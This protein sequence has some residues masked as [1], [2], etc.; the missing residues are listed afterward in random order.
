MNSL[1]LRYQIQI[2][3]KLNHQPEFKLAPQKLNPQLVRMFDNPTMQQQQPARAIQQP[4]KQPVPLKKEAAKTNRCGTWMLSIKQKFQILGKK[5]NA[6][7]QQ[8]LS[9]LKKP[10]TPAKKKMAATPIKSQE[11][12]FQLPL[13]KPVY[14]VRP[15]PFIPVPAQ[16]PHY[17][18][19]KSINR[20][21]PQPKPI[22]TLTMQPDACQNEAKQALPEQAITL[23]E[24]FI[25]P[26]PP[27]PQPKPQISLITVQTNH[28]QSELESILPQKQVEISCEENKPEEQVEQEVQIE[29]KAE[30]TEQMM[31]FPLS[32]SQNDSPEVGEEVKEESHTPP[33]APPLPPRVPI[34][35]AAQ[36]QEIVKPAFRLDRKDFLNEIAQFNKDALKKQEVNTS[37]NT[38]P[39]KDLKQEDDL[40]ELVKKK[41]IIQREPLEDEEEE[42]EVSQTPPIPSTP[43]K[44]PSQ[45]QGTSNN[46]P[47]VKRTGL[48][49]EIEGFKKENLKKA[50]KIN[51]DLPV[52][53]ETASSRN[54]LIKQFMN[55]VAHIGRK[56]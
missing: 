9:F 25:R 32:T 26:L 54:N 28:N 49:N 55:N 53:S 17:T 13:T 1:Q 34:P 19:P 24:R 30:K 42:E 21:L 52:K 4:K 47:R 7:C 16:L 10:F 29:V 44:A 35:V 31:E 38:P 3:Q 51:K 6:C 18:P 12:L 8:V 11:Q 14:V 37:E 43:P 41:L 39:I 33:P 23:Q 5:I 56:H 22:Q 36:K 40:L 45:V 27:L 46:P 2:N 50:K 48:L 15:L 20:P